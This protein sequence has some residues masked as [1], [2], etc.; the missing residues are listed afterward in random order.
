ML[1][2]LVLFAVSVGAVGLSMLS[3]A[4]AV[5][6]SVFSFA[7]DTVAW[8]VSDS[9][10]VLF[11]LSVLFGS[12]G[13]G[14]AFPAVGGAFGLSAGAGAVAVLSVIW[15][16]FGVSVGELGVLGIYFSISGCSL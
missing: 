12:A 13:S 2:L 6:W 4:A 7:S 8:I 14:V 3:S 15:V 11:K 1:V 16:L 10:N 9:G 5:V